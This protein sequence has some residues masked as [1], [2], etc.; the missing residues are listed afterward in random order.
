MRAVIFDM[1]GVLSDTQ[2]I[3]GRI[4]AD[5]INRCGGN[6]TVDELARKYAGVPTSTFFR[7]LINASQYDIPALLKEKQERFLTEAKGNVREVHGARAL[8][9]R[10]KTAGLK[11][12]VASGSN[13]NVADLTLGELGLLEA[14]DAIVTADDVT[15]GKPSPDVFLEAAR[16]IGVEPKECTVIEDGVAG[17]QGARAAG[18]KVIALATHEQEYPA[19]IVV[20]SLDEITDEML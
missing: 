15:R 20:H 6:I 3:H 19:D 13:K 1:D 16:R 7:E 11:I 9:E 10:V 17:M 8:V 5:I 4:E 18:M 12:A 14:F 2:S